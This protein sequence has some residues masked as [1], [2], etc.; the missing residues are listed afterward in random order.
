MENTKIVENEQTIVTT[1]TTTEPVTGQEG[2]SRTSRTSFSIQSLFLTL[3]EEYKRST[4]FQVIWQVQI[5]KELDAR[6]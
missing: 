6:I 3:K 4:K 5:L 2:N 1:Q